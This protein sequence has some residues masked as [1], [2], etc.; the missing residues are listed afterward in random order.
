MNA[1][2]PP[3]MKAPASGAGIADY[4][5]ELLRLSPAQLRGVGIDLR[6]RLSTAA[7]QGTDTYNVPADQDLVIFGISGYYRS[8]LL[9]TEPVLN[10]AFTQFSPAE[11]Q[12][13]RAS[14]CIVG[15]ENKDRNLP[16]FDARA[17][18]L[19]AITP[20]M[21]AKLQFPVQAPLLVPRTH[22]LRASFALQDTTA[23]V[24]GNPADYGLLLEGILIPTRV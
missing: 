7:L 19:A 4:L 18:V 23:A 14:N 13:A 22:T 21:G 6:A 1:A 5:T 11:L 3:G 2:C 17:I 8:S 10:V 24:V 20:P 12:V 9:A 15:L 16:V